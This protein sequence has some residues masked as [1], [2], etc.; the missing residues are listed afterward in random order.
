MNNR[1]Q[2]QKHYT[3]LGYKFVGWVNFNQKAA[4]SVQESKDNQWHEV[5]KCLHL[6]ACHDLKVFAMVD[7]G[8]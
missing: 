6:V 2:L 1:E 5:G 3:N 8:D 4:E 7:S